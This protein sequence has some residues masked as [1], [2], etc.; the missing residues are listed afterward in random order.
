MTVRSIIMK[1]A[2]RGEADEIVIFISRERGWLTGIAKNSRK[3][4]IRF[5]GH[6]EPFCVVDIVVR[7]RQKDN[8][9]WIDEAQML[10]AFFRIRDDMELVARVSYFLELASIFLPE[11]QPEESVF[12]FLENFLES[13]HRAKPG[14]MEFLIQ[15]IRLLG[16]LGY[17]PVLSN[18]PVCEK[19]F[20]KNSEAFFSPSFGGIC[21]KDCIVEVSPIMV[22]I[23]PATVATLRH[24]LD[25][26]SKLAG[27][28]KVGRIARH[29]IRDSLS[30]F[31]RYIRGE[32]LQSLRFMEKAGYT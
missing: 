16:L 20:S 2:D 8:M 26:D 30:A 28:I 31:V 13:V 12:D 1:K 11:G 17:H 7:S 25:S 21:H 15:E 6:L 19:G 23:S 27:R 9:V 18:C 32:D 29:E 22:H 3:S 14:S 5:G 4:R 10:K 24:L